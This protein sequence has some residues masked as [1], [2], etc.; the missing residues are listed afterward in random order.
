L[1][2]RHDRLG[3]VRG[4]AALRLGAPTVQ[5]DQLARCRIEPDQPPAGSG[6]GRHAGFAGVDPLCLEQFADGESA[7]AG[8]EALHRAGTPVAVG[9]ESV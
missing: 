4:D 6:R 9:G 7:A 5:H 3:I 1:P 8:R 2:A